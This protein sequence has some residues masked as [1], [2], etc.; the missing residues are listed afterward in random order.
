MYNLVETC[1]ENLARKN[2]HKVCKVER[3]REEK[4]KKNKE[5]Y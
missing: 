4:E 1:T 3:V 5:L 2:S